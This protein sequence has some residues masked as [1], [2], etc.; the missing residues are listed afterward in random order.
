VD[1][2][3]HTFWKTSI[4][5]FSVESNT[6]AINLFTKGLVASENEILSLIKDGWLLKLKKEFRFVLTSMI[7]PT[8]CSKGP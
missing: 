1:G 6:T 5:D 4:V 8:T 7:L 3:V 2:L